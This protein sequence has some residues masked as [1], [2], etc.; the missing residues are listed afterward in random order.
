MNRYLLQVEGKSKSMILALLCSVSY[1]V[2][3]IG[4]LN[5]SAALPEMIAEGILNKTQ[6]GMIA[7]AYFAA[8]GFGQLVNGVLAD[9][10]NPYV[11]VTTGVVSSAVLNILMAFVDS[12]TWMMLE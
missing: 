4:R 6:G 5:Y 2:L 11:Q 1:A 10:Y 12:P 8:Y 7:T 9:R 3:Y